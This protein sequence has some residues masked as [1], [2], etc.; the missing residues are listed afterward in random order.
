MLIN[1]RKQALFYLFSAISSSLILIAILYRHG[2]HLSIPIN[3]T[4]DNL[5]SATIVKSIIDVGSSFFNPYLGAPYSADFS[6]F[7]LSE[8]SNFFILK[9]LSFV[10]HNP[11]VV[12]NLFFCLS[13]PLT[14][15]ISLFVFQRLGLNKYFALTASLLFSFLPY[16]FIRIEYGHLFLCAIYVIPIYVLLISYI[17]KDPL[18]FGPSTRNRFLIFLALAAV[19]LFSASSGVYYAFFATYLLLIAG[20]IA[21]FE[22]KRWYPLANAGLVI[23]LLSLTIVLNTLPA[24]LAQIKNGRNHEVAQRIPAESEYYGL[25]ISQLLLPVDK[26]HITSLAK[27]KENYNTSALSVNEN[28][29]ATLGIVGSIGFLFLLFT[30]IIKKLQSNQDT[31]FNLSRLTIAAILFSTIGGF[32]S[33]FAYLVS[34][35]LRGQN[36]ISVFIAFFSLGAFFLVV[37]HLFKNRSLKIGYVIGALVLVIGLYDQVPR[38]TFSNYAAQYFSDK[39]FVTSIEAKMPAGTMIMQLPYVDY[40]ESPNVQGLGSYTHFRG[41]LHSHNLHWSFGAMRGRHVAAWQKLIS[42]KSTKQML[43]ELVYAGFTGLYLNNSGYPDHGVEIEKQITNI[44]R[45]GPTL[46]TE[47][48]EIAFYDLRPYANALRQSMTSLA[49]QTQQNRVNETI[50]S[51]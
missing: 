3:Y 10:S 23:F 37:Q 18:L 20:L 34:P 7:P 41:Y 1:N 36:R 33:L 28:R 45:S 24:T 25:K 26:H 8:Y 2:F 17:L 51:L 31:L 42:S 12:M 19:C 47:D 49:W 27:F 4:S 11:I 46:K 40:P 39:N 29:S 30:L 9:L 21:S 13:F 14:T 22:K 50:A 44:L 48:G 5:I 16:S 38:T 15:V 35:M 6:D 32:S 43:N